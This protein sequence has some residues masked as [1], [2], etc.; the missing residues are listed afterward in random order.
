M[1]RPLVAALAGTIVCTA[2]P[3]AI[4]AYPIDCAILLCLAGG[5]PPSAPCVAARAEMI[6]RIT[7]WPIEPPLQLWRCPMQGAAMEDPLQRLQR[8][9][10]VAGP[11]VEN[12]RLSRAPEVDG[13]TPSPAAWAPMVLVRDV[14]LRTASMDISAEAFDFIRA[15]RVFDVERI[16]QRWSGG[17]SSTCHQGST[18]RLGSYDAEGAFSWRTV[19]V[20]SLP[21]AF[22]GAAGWQSSAS[23]ISSGSDCP[24]IFVRAVFIEWRDQAGNYDFEQ[25]PY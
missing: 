3:A 13:Q 10:M 11:S 12:L 21:E 6:R 17:D 4:A 19:G 7:P 1:K 5:F 22:E 9:I 23:H 24:G 8:A 14:E 18:I 16:S 15:I 2:T 20:G 25:V